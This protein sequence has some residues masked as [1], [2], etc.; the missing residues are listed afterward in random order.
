MASRSLTGALLTGPAWLFRY[1]PLFVPHAA[2]LDGLGGFFGLS[3]TFPS[4]RLV[5]RSPAAKV[6]LAVIA[7]DLPW[8]HIISHGLPPP[9]GSSP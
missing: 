4:R 5:A 6:L 9:R 8:S 7:H 1:A 3:S 2:V